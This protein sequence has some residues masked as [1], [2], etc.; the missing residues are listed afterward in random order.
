VFEGSNGEPPRRG[1]RAQKRSELDLQKGFSAPEDKMKKKTT[2]RR[3][4]RYRKSEEAKRFKGGKWRKTHAGQNAACT[5]VRKQKKNKGRAER[6]DSEH[7]RI[8]NF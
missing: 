2:T 6:G 4:K 1:L 8:R 5:P 7:C 3:G